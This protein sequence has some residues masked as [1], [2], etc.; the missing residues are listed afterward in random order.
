MLSFGGD[1]SQ[2]G[3]PGCR[4]ALAG[5]FSG[6]VAVA[7]RSLGD[8]LPPL[9]V[10]LSLGPFL[11]WPVVGSIGFALVAE[12]FGN[13]GSWTVLMCLARASLLVNDRSHSVL[14]SFVVTHHRR[15]HQPTR[16][17]AEEWLLLC[18][19]PH[20]RLQRVSTRM[21]DALPCAV[22]PFASILCSLR[23]D[24]FVLHMTNQTV[25]VSQFSNRTAVPLA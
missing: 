25:G 16:Q 2:F 19:A 3:S 18:M 14:V 15:M 6:L 4:P 10:N 24:M 20:M 5:F 7:E 11:G 1:G 13:S 23:T 9:A 8:D 12:A 21:V 22:S 17:R